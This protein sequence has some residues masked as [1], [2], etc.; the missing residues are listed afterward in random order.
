MAF[1]TDLSEFYSAEEFAEV[2]THEGASISA[3]FF[4]VR[5][6]I[7]S[8]YIN[9]TYFTA[10]AENVASII[11]GDLILRGSIE[12][13]VKSV[14]D[15]NSDKTIKVVELEHVRDKA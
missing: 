7:D 11:K 12:Y 9:H 4:D 14:T 10:P 3:M 5:E 13:R 8:V 6:D 15:H 2:I 1:S